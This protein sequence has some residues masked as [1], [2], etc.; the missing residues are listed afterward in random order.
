M[1]VLKRN[2][3]PHVC[4]LILDTGTLEKIEVWCAESLGHRFHEWYSYDVMHGRTYGFKDESVLLV[5][6]LKWGQY[7]YKN[8]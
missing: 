2:I 8:A 4:T 1:R 6:K 5:F 3:W 7:V